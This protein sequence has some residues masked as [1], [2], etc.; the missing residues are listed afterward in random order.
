MLPNPYDGSTVQLVVLAFV[1]DDQR[2]GR[3]ESPSSR[4]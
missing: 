1:P 3:H 2:K 4:F